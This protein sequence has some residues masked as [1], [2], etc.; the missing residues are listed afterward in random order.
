MLEAGSPPGEMSVRVVSSDRRR[1]ATY[2]KAT[3]GVTKVRIPWV[4]KSTA[5]RLY[6]SNKGVVMGDG[7]SSEAKTGKKGCKV[8]KMRLQKSS[9]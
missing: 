9:I 5:M 3:V 8:Y 1:G 6:K 7:T 4:T 2:A